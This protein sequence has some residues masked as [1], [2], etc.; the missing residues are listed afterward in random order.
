[1]PH[2][3]M[4]LTGQTAVALGTALL[5][6][7]SKPRYAHSGLEALA[8][9]FSELRSMSLRR[10]LSFVNNLQRPIAPSSSTGVRF[11]MASLL[12]RYWRTK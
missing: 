10:C 12:R 6:Q 8:H 7:A 3:P 1:M 2:R 4:M 9:R 11:E 5:E